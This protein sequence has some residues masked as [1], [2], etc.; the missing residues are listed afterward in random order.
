MNDK[1]SIL[2]EEFENGQTGDKVP[3]ITIIVDGKI[4]EVMDLL[5]EK[6]PQYKNYIDVVKTAFFAGIGQIIQETKR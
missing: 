2:Q 6:N 5:I 1:V 3:G 4:R